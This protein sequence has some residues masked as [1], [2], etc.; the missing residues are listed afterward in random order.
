[1]LAVFISPLWTGAATVA[2]AAG[3]AWLVTA[4]G[5]RRGRTWGLV[6]TVLLLLIILVS[7][8]LGLAA[9][10]DP[11]GHIVPLAYGLLM[12]AALLAGALQAPPHN[13]QADP[14]LLRPAGTRHAG[15]STERAIDLRNGPD[16]A[17]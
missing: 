1:M 11:S 4:I 2:S 16:K 5:L 3:L 17:T 15:T 14:S 12:L 10:R 7:P 13:R 6:G 8:V 9:G